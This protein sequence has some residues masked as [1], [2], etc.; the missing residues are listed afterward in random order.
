M[1]L[2]KVKI[3]QSWVSKIQK[4]WDWSIFAGLPA[5]TLVFALGEAA[6]AVGPVWMQRE[7]LDFSVSS[8][9]NPPKGRHQNAWSGWK[10]MITKQRLKTLWNKDSRIRISS[11]HPSKKWKYDE[12]W[13]NNLD[14]LSIGWPGI[15]SFSAPK[16][17]QGIGPAG[18]MLLESFL[19]S[20]ECCLRDPMGRAL[21]QV[22]A[23]WCPRTKH[24]A[25]QGAVS[26]FVF[27]SWFSIK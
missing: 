26:S 4:Y 15:H 5:T 8:P 14:Q 6:A 18:A 23:K 9:W 7:A 1:L 27:I 24:L 11:F 17:L 16:Q 25:T 10:W 19:R 2:K 21:L 12:I 22:Q 13:T 20:S 3:L